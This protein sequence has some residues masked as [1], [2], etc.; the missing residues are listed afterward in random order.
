MHVDMQMRVHTYMAGAHT[1]A[2]THSV[3]TWLLSGT[4]I[5]DRRECDNGA[6]QFRR[7]QLVL[8]GRPHRREE[9]MWGVF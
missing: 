7:A 3:C 6:S 8:R 4:W 2:C 1:R 5:G 9:W